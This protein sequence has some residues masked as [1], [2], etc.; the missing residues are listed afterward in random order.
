MTNV[1]KADICHWDSPERFLCL[2]NQL[3]LRKPVGLSLLVSSIPLWYEKKLIQ[4]AEAQTE[5]QNVGIKVI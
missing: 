2:L 1:E 5:Q 4:T 3:T